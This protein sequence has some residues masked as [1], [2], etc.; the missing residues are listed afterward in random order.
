MYWRKAKTTSAGVIWETAK[1][2]P[3]IKSACCQ[4]VLVFPP[5]TRARGG[6]MP[7]YT[8]RRVRSHNGAISEYA[9]NSLRQFSYSASRVRLKRAF[10]HATGDTSPIFSAKEKRQ[11]ASFL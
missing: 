10:S 6:P 8:D 9:S 2:S 5:N 11:Q 3:I 7:T 4:T 1:R